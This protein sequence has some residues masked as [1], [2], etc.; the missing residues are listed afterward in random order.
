MDISKSEP[1]NA[2]LLLFR[3]TGPENFATLSAEQRQGLINDWNDWYQML[4]EAGKATE[5]QPLEDETRV[6]TGPGGSRITDGPFPEAK[7]AIGGYVKVLASTFD[8]ATE[9]AQ[10]HPALKYGMV[11]EIRQMTMDCHLGVSAHHTPAEACS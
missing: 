11:I 10:Q 8:Q 9:I 2:Y 4:A 5:G 7:E 3:N 1:T 6:V